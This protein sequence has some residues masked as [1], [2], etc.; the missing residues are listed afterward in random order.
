M[1]K[2]TCKYVEIPIVFVRLG[3]LVLYFYPLNDHISF[4]GEFIA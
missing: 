1:Q 4:K 2:L 3:N